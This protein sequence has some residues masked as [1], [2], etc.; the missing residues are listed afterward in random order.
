LPALTRAKESA[1]ATACANNLRQLYAGVVMYTDENDEWLPPAHVRD[2]NPDYNESSS[3]TDFYYLYSWS[4]PYGYDPD[5][6]N[7]GYTH[8]GLLYD[9]G[10]LQDGD[11]YYCPGM[12]AGALTRH[13]Y[14]PWPT[15]GPDKGRI[16]GS[17]YYNPYVTVS[18]GDG[19]TGTRIYETISRFPEGK[20]MIFDI[21]WVDGTKM[22]K[23]PD[24]N[25][26]WGMFAWNITRTDGST[27][28]IQPDRDEMMS[29]SARWRT[30]GNNQSWSAFQDAL[31][32]IEQ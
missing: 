25:A 4:G 21:L 15:P 11:V 19:G 10:L 18:G 31:D 16:R 23:V 32:L 13:Y 14:D 22:D 29:I 5:H 9:T 7:R 6:W 3:P 17:Y 8:L 30:A 2:I 27:A 28:L 1:R 26:H 20:V 24:L 12:Q